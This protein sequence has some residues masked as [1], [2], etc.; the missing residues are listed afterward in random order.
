MSLV[1][2]MPNLYIY[3]GRTGVLVPF[4]QQSSSNFETGYMKKR[5][6]LIQEILSKRGWYHGAI[7]GI[8]GRKT[9]CA[10][11]RIDHL[12]IEWP[13][14]RVIVAAIQLLAEEAGIPCQPVD[15]YWGPVTEHAYISLQYY[16]SSGRLPAK[17]RPEELSLHNPNG[18]PKQYSPEFDHF[19][20]NRGSSLVRVQLPYAL[21]LAWNT[22]QKVN[23]FLCHNKVKNS[24]ENVLSKVLDH[25]G[26]DE[27]R[28]LR[29]DLWGG[30]YNERP[31]R[32][33]TKWSMH[34]WG[35]A[36]D[37]DPVRNRLEWGRDKASFAKD[38]YDYWWKCW[39]EEGWISLGRTRNF[40]WMHVQAAHL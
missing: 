39:E 27:I 29:L 25:Y 22:D 23:S 24:I 30:C 40:D 21:R 18:W 11:A 6:Q 20:G 3:V 38:D 4:G 32:G 34:S 37:F 13:E 17:W 36:L 10:I 12:N 16:V 14:K 9:R 31:I 1:S 2:L 35:I 19:Y 33:G 7:D 15:G 5:L 26:A 8:I 28:R